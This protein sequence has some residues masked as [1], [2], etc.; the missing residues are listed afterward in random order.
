LDQLLVFDFYNV[1]KKKLGEG[2]DDNLLYI[3]EIVPKQKIFK[4]VKLRSQE[5]TPLV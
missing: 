1:K 3:K 5:K 2:N 4:C